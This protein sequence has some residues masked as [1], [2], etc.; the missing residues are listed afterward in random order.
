MPSA[1]ESLLCA[2]AEW[3]I[4]SSS[5]NTSKPENVSVSQASVAGGWDRHGLRNSALLFLGNPILVDVSIKPSLV[6][7]LQ[8]GCGKTRKCP[9]LGST[10]PSTVPGR[11]WSSYK[12]VGNDQP[13]ENDSCPSSPPCC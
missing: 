3:D 12:G 2:V 10:G 13:R 5:S 1:A 11:T 6:D 7:G 4:S 9:G 8:P